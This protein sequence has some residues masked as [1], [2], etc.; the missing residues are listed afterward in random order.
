MRSS[1]SN[2]FWCLVRFWGVY[3]VKNFSAPPLFYSFIFYWSACNAFGNLS[4]SQNKL[5][6]IYYFTNENLLII[7]LEW[8]NYSIWSKAKLNKVIIDL[9]QPKLS[10][11]QLYAAF[12][13]WSCIIIVTELYIFLSC[14]KFKIYWID[15]IWNRSI[16]F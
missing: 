7:L 12:K 5:I 4:L 6:V 9:T 11:K 1:Q 16:F 10:Q 15:C 3:L 2:Q 14:S 13:R 8:K